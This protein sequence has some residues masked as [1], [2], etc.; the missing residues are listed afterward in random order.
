MAGVSA[1]PEVTAC[2][3]IIPII[4]ESYVIL[5]TYFDCLYLSKIVTSS[6]GD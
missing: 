1:A 3:L 2:L 6:S 4:V 5:D